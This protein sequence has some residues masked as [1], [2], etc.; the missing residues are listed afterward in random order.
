MQALSPQAARQALSSLPHWVLAA[1]GRAMH[2]QLVFDDFKQA[3]AFMTQVALAAEQRN[4]HPDWHNV[5]NRVDIRLST[6]DAGGLTERDLELARWIDA[7]Q[8]TLKR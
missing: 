2:R 8:V 4:H 5:Y 3:F 1:D 7:Q 6:H